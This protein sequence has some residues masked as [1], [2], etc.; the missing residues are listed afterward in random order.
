MAKNPETK[1]TF[2]VFNKE[3]NKAISQMKDES[4][5]LRKEYQLQEEQ[6]KQN[7]TE[8]ERFSAKLNYLKDVQELTKQQISATEEQLSKAKET[9][10]ENS[11]EADKLAK[12]LLDI[13]I[14]EQKL[15]N[16]I[17][18][19]EKAQ[20]DS[21]LATKELKA[22]LEVTNS[23][24]SDYAD[25]LGIDLVKAIE[26]G[27]ASSRDMKTA[28]EKIAKSALGST[29][30]IEKIKK[31][32]ASLDDGA[33]TM[34]V[35]KELE[36]IGKEAE[37]A[38]ESVNE[39]GGELSNLAG[40]LAAGAG[41]AGTVN[42]ALGAS[43]LN[44]KIDITL[45]VPEESKKSIKDAVKE[46]ES[47]GIDG[48]S[49][50][51]GV[52][53]QWILNKTASDEVNASIV[54]GAATIVSS[55]SGIDFIELIQETNEISNELKISKEEAIGL[56][57][58]L[59]KMGFPS[60]QLDII[61]EYG[62][63][64][65]RAGYNGKE[66]QAL[67]QAGVNTGTWNIDNLMDG[68]KE[69]RILVSEFGQEIPEAMK[70][71]LEITGISEKQMQEWGRA[72]ASGG[73]NGS[74]A[75]TDI[76][77]AL[78]GVKDETIKNALGVQL[79]GTLYEEQGQN[80]TN[81][82]INAK[83]VT[84]DLKE[85][86]DQLNESASK[87]DSDPAIKMKQA[88]TDVM[89]ASEPLLLKVS[90]LVSKVAD[91]TSKNPQLT[92]TIIAITTAI[93]ILMGIFLALTPIVITLSTLATALGVSIGAIS[94]P[95]VLIVAGIA[96]LI[97][98]GVLL[99]KNWDKL[100]AKSGE[101]W[102]KLG[103]FK[104]ILIALTGPIGILIAAGISLYKNWDTIKEK[105]SK[106]IGSVKSNFNELKDIDLKQIGKDVINGFINGIK[107]K[108]TDVKN[109]VKEAANAVTSKIKDVLNINS[110]SRV[111]MEMGE[112]TGEGF[113]I[114]IDKMNK[115]VANASNKLA[116]TAIPVGDINSRKHYQETLNEGL[117]LTL[118]NQQ[119]ISITVVSELDGHEV[120]RNQYEYIENMM[121]NNTQL[122][123]NSRGVR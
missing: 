38:Q 22:L 68:L 114:G 43:S 2:K 112:D 111:L 89:I 96:A 26:N 67:F 41:I 119:P 23:E 42:Q 79:F 77:I 29:A 86:Q 52:R 99:W 61:A 60:E 8:T 49:A 94:L 92:S 51:E 98:I 73:A 123:L 118:P 40:G 65:E 69:G 72:V 64:L 83:D 102:S 15:S 58:S 75:M 46:I 24:V 106:F 63:Q 101:L 84:V 47:Y 71:L 82:L 107:S 103:N 105:G 9:F 20:R 74:K 18:T 121:H 1:V 95:V 54:K 35:K 4:T 11:I 113:V 12:K 122:K 17:F 5:K 16:E 13:Q 90:N 45:D 76:A 10:G 21:I 108:I 70:P 66:I 32:L 50:L 30:D 27:T 78:N 3:F 55:Y 33:S 97:A 36:L 56:T 88:L 117:S 100:R 62:G 14:A 19:T 109:V 31:S 104:L 110:P 25:T 39:L 6:L 57:N 53:R 28:L 48:E 44:T 93:G 37:T 7:G 80:I 116:E 59:L 81:T 115:A 87:L 85:N 34:A 91:W 120:A